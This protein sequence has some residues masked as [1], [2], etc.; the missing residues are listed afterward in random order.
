[1]KTII[2]YF[3]L[4]FLACNLDDTSTQIQTEMQTKAFLINDT[5]FVLNMTNFS[6]KYIDC[7]ESI[8]KFLAKTYRF[9]HSN[10]H[11]KPTTDT[12]MLQARACEGKV[13]SEAVSATEFR[14]F[15]C[16]FVYAT[17]FIVFPCARAKNG[18]LKTM[19]LE[20]EDIGILTSISTANDIFQ[21]NIPGLNKSIAIL[22]SG[23]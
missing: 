15:M 13:C 14:E 11:E 9:I 1:M 22:K 6:M 20:K 23:N 16:D 12:E 7:I 8:D 5:F 19:H 3:L 2:V 21:C 18:D 4:L 10:F 17:I